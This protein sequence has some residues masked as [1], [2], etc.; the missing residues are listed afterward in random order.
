MHSSKKVKNSLLFTCYKDRTYTWDIRLSIQ[1][2]Y[3]QNKNITG[4]NQRKNCH[5]HQTNYL[6]I[7]QKQQIIVKDEFLHTGVKNKQV[8]QN[9]LGCTK[10]NIF[11]SKKN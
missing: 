4:A 3:A 10:S 7:S 2:K 5:F 6:D 1:P 8:N 11:L 9:S